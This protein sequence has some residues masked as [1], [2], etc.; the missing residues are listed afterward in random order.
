MMDVIAPPRE[1]ARRTAPQ[2]KMKRQGGLVLATFDRVHLKSVQR[3]WE[4]LIARAAEDNVYYSPNY[5]L[6]LLETVGSGTSV[7]FVTAWDG[8]RLMAFMPVVLNKLPIPGLRP[9]GRAWETDYTFGCTPMLDRSEPERAAAGLVDALAA[10]GRGDWALPHLNVN[11]P[12]WR[13]LT[14]ALDRRGV[15]WLINQP[16]SRAS[17]SVGPSFEDHMRACVGSKRRRELTRSRRRLEELGQLSHKSCTSGAAL[18]DAV[19]A[20]LKLEASGWKGRRGTALACKEDSAAFARKAFANDGNGRTARADMLL[21]DDKPIAI[22]LIVF[23]GQT[24][25][26]VKGTYDEAY[27]QYGAGLIL[28]VEVIKS[29]LEERWAE[30]LDAATNGAHVIDRLWPGRIEVGELV[31]SFARGAAH[32]RLMA[33]KAARSLKSNSKAWIKR[34]IAR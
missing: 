27:S 14:A 2:W 7:R 1:F 23:S 33:Y 28:E 9:I 22:G 20:F 4:D 5:A 34:I 18:D 24:G 15:P 30:Q 29:F 6:S 31:F 25:F 13:A 3:E 26:T 19:A 8:D 11:G 16:Y 17:L 10:L 21:L 32:Q 12:V